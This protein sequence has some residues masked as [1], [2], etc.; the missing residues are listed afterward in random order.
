MAQ[1]VTVAGASYSDVPSVVLP[2]TGGGSATFLDTTITSNAASASDIAS[3]KYAYVNGSLVEGTGSGGGGGGV[4]VTTTPDAHGGDIVEITAVDLSS[5]TVAANKMLS[6]TTAHDSS[7]AAVT[8]SIASKTSADIA[9]SGDTVTVPAGHYASQ[10]TKS[11]ASGSATT[12]ATTVTANPTISVNSSTGVITATA[13]ATQSVTPTVS[14]GYVSS[15]TAGT[16]T[17]SGSN[18]SN[19]TTQAAQTIHP[20][21][22]DQTISSGKYLTGTQT[23]KAVTHNLT[24]GIIKSGEVVKIGDSTDDDCV[25]SITGTY[26]GGGSS[27]AFYCYTGLASRTANSYGSTSAT[28]T[29]TKAGTYTISYVAIRGSSSGTMGTNLHIGSSSGTN[30]TTWNNGTYGQAV[31]L[32]GQSISANTAVTIYATSGSNSRSIYVGQLIVQEE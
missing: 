30:N 6:G 17:V 25:T 12:P 4:V 29:V 22:S 32:T 9:V 21:T 11:V 5:D 3:G 16:I 31:T 2:K 20:S 26:T 10:A 7:G 23:I 27:K 28:V 15:G 1:N 14:A 24:A 19:L 8:G 18:T 13:S